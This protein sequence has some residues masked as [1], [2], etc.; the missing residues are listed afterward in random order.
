[1]L[2]PFE[3]IYV[4]VPFCAAKCDYCA[5][6]SIPS[7]PAELRS[8]YLERLT[9]ELTAHAD[10]CSTIASVYVGGGTPTCL[11]DDELLHML[12]DLWS[13]VTPADD[14]E[15]TVE[16]N[17]ATLTPEKIDILAESGV[18]RVSLGVQSFDPSLRLAIGRRT[19]PGAVDIVAG[20]LRRAGIGNIGLDLIFA[21]PGQTTAQWENDLETACSLA[22]SHVSTYELTIEEGTRLSARHVSR[23]SD[24]T[25]VRMWEAAER[26]SAGAG[27]RRYEV[28]NL[29]VRGRECRH[30]LAVWHGATY[31][32]LGPAGTSFDGESRRT[33]PADLEAWLTGERGDQDVLAPDAR[34]VEVL[35]IG[36]RT[37]DGW[38][39]LGFAER[40]GFDYMQLRGPVLGEMA[41]AGLL[42]LSEV[43]VRPTKRGLLLADRVARDLL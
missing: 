4:H 32:G 33:N 8:A 21:I 38:D 23:P 12:K 25:I 9:A 7:A 19:D 26:V 17:P 20:Q 11:T 43:G 6:Y 41:R 15:F 18:N 2:R 14:V 22:P 37:C 27:L 34:A 1:M 42:E 35:A 24:A 40:T 39:R 10:Q 5:F 30:N 28:S 3:S 29:A 13:R 36:L 31:L 16:C